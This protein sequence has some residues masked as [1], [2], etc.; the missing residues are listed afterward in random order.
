MALRWTGGAELGEPTPE[1]REPGERSALGASVV[2][3]GAWNV[4][5]QGATV[6]ASLVATP[7]VIRALGSEL[8]GLLALINAVVGYMVFADLGMAPASSRF[9]AAARAAGDDAAEAAVVWTSLLLAAVPALA[10]AFLI[11][12][13]APTIAVDVLRLSPRVIDEAVAALRIVSLGLLARALAGVVNTPQI[14]RMKWNVYAAITYGGTTLQTVLVPVVLALGGGFVAAVS[15]GTVVS[16]VT[17]LAHTV[18]SA[19]LQRGLWPPRLRRNVVRPLLGFG[20]GILASHMT[21]VLL[22]TVDRPV[23]ARLTSLDEVGYYAVAASAAAL[24]NVIPFA[25]GQPL[26]PAFT[27]LLAQDGEEEAGRLFSRSVRFMVIVIAPVVVVLV[28]TARPFLSV[29]AGEEF[30]RRSAVPFYLLVGGFAFNAIAAVPGAL[31]MAR[32]R[33]RLLAVYHAVQLVP[34]LLLLVVLASRWGGEGAAA[35]W[36]LRSAA[37][38]LLYFRG[39]HRVLSTT[40]QPD[41]SFFQA[42]STP[43]LILVVP[44]ATVVTT[45]T[46]V[47]TLGTLSSASLLA[48]SGVVWRRVLASEERSLVITMA[49]NGIEAVRRHLGGRHD[50]TSKS[51]Q[52]EASECENDQG[53][54]WM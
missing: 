30:A 45:S 23:L 38:A 42:W 19:R 20:T 13:L 39:A 32:T 9:G 27:L 11:A 33:V 29:W 8:Y 1:A 28:V 49:R 40:R 14:A 48:Y 44:L 7:F 26:F 51:E 53:T 4:G 22:Q 46:A 2:R 41:A 10:V 18:V 24:L 47:L 12:V 6:L 43:A 31:L 16:F 17:L 50:L 54:R 34:Y 37:N 52:N 36:A 21:L 15:V 35:A 3:G 5:G 25:I